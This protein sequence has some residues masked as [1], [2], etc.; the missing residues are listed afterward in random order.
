MTKIFICYASEDKK[1]A[2]ELCEKLVKD[3]FEPWLDKKNLLPGQN[4]R[5]EIPKV[6]RNSGCMIVLLSST[7]VSKRGYVQKEFKLALEI[8]NESPED[9]ISLIPVKI[10]EC[11]IPSM[12]ESL[13]WVY[14]FEDGGYEKVLE[15]ISTKVKSQNREP[16]I[17]SSLQPTNAISFVDVWY[18]LKPYGVYAFWRKAD[19]GLLKIDITEGKIIFNSKL[20]KNLIINRKQIIKILSDKMPGDMANS[21]VKIIFRDVERFL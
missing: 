12:F 18:R 15:S 3:G 11:T 2:N 7:S 8:Y 21:W 19:A 5:V 9:D 13:H 17:K 16:Q 14:L 20:T 6:M 10:D 4:W 1:I